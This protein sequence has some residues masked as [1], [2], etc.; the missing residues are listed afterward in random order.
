[1][2][3]PHQPRFVRLGAEQVDA[4]FGAGAKLRPRVE[5]SGGRFV[6]R[7]RVSVV[8]MVGRLDGVAVVGPVEERAAI[9][10]GPG[11]LER[12]GVDRTGGLLLIGPNGECRIGPA[13]LES[14]A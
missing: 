7:E 1:V 9:R 6:A 4:L 13:T 10:L 3:K 12:L 11:D 5:I 8:G 2:R 14:A